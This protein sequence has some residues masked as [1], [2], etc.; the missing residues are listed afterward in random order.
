MV[1]RGTAVAPAGETVFSG[2]EGYVV[3][4]VRDFFAGVGDLAG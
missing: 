3:T 2:G 4:G 1:D